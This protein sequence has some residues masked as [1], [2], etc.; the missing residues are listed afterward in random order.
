M[1]SIRVKSVL[2]RSIVDLN[3]W[4]PSSREVCQYLDLRKVPRMNHSVVDQAEI[5]RIVV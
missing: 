2:R 3:V 5:D 1:L 4:F